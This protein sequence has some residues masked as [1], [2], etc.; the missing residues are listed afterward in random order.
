[1][2]EVIPEFLGTSIPYLVNFSTYLAQC[3]K[4]IWT[5]NSPKRWITRVSYQTNTLETQYLVLNTRDVEDAS[6]IIETESPISTTHEMISNTK[7]PNMDGIQKLRL[8]PYTTCP[9]LVGRVNNNI[10]LSHS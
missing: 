4:M 9:R 6:H 2:E 10:N 8:A 3:N 7:K 1:M 5:R